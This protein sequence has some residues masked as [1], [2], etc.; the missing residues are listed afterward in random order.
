MW[1]CCI[2]LLSKKQNYGTNIKKYWVAS[3]SK[4]SSSVVFLDTSTKGTS[5]DT[6][7]HL[8]I[9]W[10][11]PAI[12]VATVQRGVSCAAVSKTQARSMSR[13]EDRT[14]I[15]PRFC[16]HI[17]GHQHAQTRYVYTRRMLGVG[18]T[19]WWSLLSTLYQQ[20]RA[21]ENG[22]LLDTITIQNV[23]YILMYQPAVMQGPMVHSQG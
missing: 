14:T 5:A 9:C 10:E 2:T 21:Q 3:S 17:I 16:P 19:W 23:I 4:A 7:A 6:A 13:V 20:S 8:E 1:H 11:V 18:E 15:G 22:K 12:I